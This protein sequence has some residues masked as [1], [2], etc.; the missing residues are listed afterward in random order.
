MVGQRGE[1][2]G[3]ARGGETAALAAAAREFGP[4]M[5]RVADALEAAMR[6]LRAGAAPP[7]YAS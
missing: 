5:A 1:A 6:E 2:L 4:G 3:R 7:G